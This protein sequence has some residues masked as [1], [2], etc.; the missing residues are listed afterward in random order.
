M[1]RPILIRNATLVL[2]DAL[3]EDG[4]L[5]IQ[6]GRIT[7]VGHPDDIPESEV[8]AIDAEGGYL[9]PGFIDIHVHG[10]GGADFMDGTEDAVATA[11]KTHTRHGTTT[12]FPT[13]TTGSPAQIDA[14]LEACANVR[15]AWQPADGARLEGVHFY[16]PYFAADKCGIHADSGR[17]D[18]IAAEYRTAFDRGI[19]RVATC[20][21]EL[22]GAEEFYREASGRGYLVTCG[23]S[24]ASWSEMQ[25]GFDAGM[26]HVDHFWCAMSS[27]A[28]VRQRLGS[29]MQGSMEQFVLFND[30]MSTEVLADGEHLSPELLQF[31]FRF[32]GSDQLCLV[33][34]AS[35]AV[36]MPQGE[37]RF[38]PESDGVAFRNNGRVGE[39]LGGGLASTVVGM[40]H[41]VR[42]MAKDSG[43]S[44]P[45]VIRMASLTP[46]RLTGID[47]RTGS[48]ED[49]KDADLLLL[50]EALK[51]QRV[52]VRGVESAL[53]SPGR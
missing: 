44:L 28:S 46:A 33:T 52:W 27:V 31:A 23:H 11:L 35:R 7:G 14:M 26:R 1:S 10:G 39:A 15:D 24:N 13:T 40:D 29:P 38:G 30:G 42:Q 8:T 34:D 50:D 19:V 20:A 2:P 49:G 16:G 12:I 25:R 45:E 5:M 9:C 22:P 36:D 21:A 43:A 48:I 47:D 32:K 41:M 53:M 51:L 17:R 37:Y 18:P 6:N 3:I 4:S